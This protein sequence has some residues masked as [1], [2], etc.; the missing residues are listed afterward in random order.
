MDLFRP[1]KQKGGG[2]GGLGFFGD[3]EPPLKL[4]EKTNKDWVQ[5]AMKS[6]GEEASKVAKSLE[7][8]MPAEFARQD[9]EMI[10]SLFQRAEERLERWENE[11]ADK[12]E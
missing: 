10:R 3:D 5:T 2:I 7:G 6:L 11:A 4:K 12:A 1:V 8:D 9:L